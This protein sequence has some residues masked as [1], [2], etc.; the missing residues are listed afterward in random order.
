MRFP[1]TPGCGQLVVVVWGPL[2]LLA[3]APGC[4]SPPL[5]AGVR[6]LRWGVSWGWVVS[7]VVCVCGVGGCVWCSCF[8]VFCV[9]VVSVFLVVW[10]GGVVWVC[11]PHALVCVLAC[12]WCVGGLCLL[13]P[14]CLGCGLRLVFAWVWLVCVVGP[15]PLLA[16]N[17]GCSSPQVLAGVY[18]LVVVVGPSPQLAEGCGCGAP[19]LLAGVRRR[20]LWVVPRPSQ[21]LAEGRGRGSPPLLA[22]V[23]WLWWW[24]LAHHSWLWA[25]GCPSRWPWCVCV[26]AAWCLMLVWVV[27]GGRVWC[28]CGVC[29]CACGVWFVGYVIPGSVRIV[30]RH[31]QRQKKRSCRC[32]AEMCVS[33]TYR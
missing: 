23:R 17:L 2:P 12:A 27:C 20:Q 15:L 1:A 10:C 7:R 8:C 14:A 11:L 29:V 26:C 18:C 24:G 4:G 33:H 19:P 5:L 13:V 30:G 16:E 9:F 25:P 21:L 31:G 22:G 6:R 28:A 3:A 32:V